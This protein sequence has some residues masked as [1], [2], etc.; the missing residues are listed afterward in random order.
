ME[1]TLETTHVRVC[2]PASKLLI[3]ALVV[4]A[5]NPHFSTL[6]SIGTLACSSACTF[7][8]SQCQ[9]LAVSSATSCPIHIVSR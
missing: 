6:R 7:D 3:I 2:S 8:T 4:C 9:P 5:S 1:E